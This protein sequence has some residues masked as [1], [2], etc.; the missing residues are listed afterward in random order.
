M[1]STR[2]ARKEARRATARTSATV[3]TR[4]TVRTRATV[5]TWLIGDR[6]IVWLGPL[7][8]LMAGTAGCTLAVDLD[9]LSQSDGSRDSRAPS[10]GVIAEASADAGADRAVEQ[11]GNF[12]A[13]A[14]G[15]HETDGAVLA[16]DADAGADGPL[17]P[18]GSSDAG[19][20]VQGS[21]EDS[22]AVVD[23]APYDAYPASDR[24]PPSERLDAGVDPGTDAFDADAGPE[25][26]TDQ[27]AASDGKDGPANDAETDV[28][29]DAMS[30][31]GAPSGPVTCDSA[32][33]VSATLHLLGS[34]PQVTSCGYSAADAPAFYAAVD[35]ETF[36]ASAACGVCLRIQTPAGMVAAMMVDLGPNRTA[37]NLTAIALNRD[38]LQ[39]LAPDGAT[40]V[41]QGVEWRRIPCEVATR[42]MTFTF[43]VGSNPSYAAVLIRNH[44]HGLAKVEYK[45]GGG[46]KELE[47]TSYNYWLAPTGMGA[48]PFTFRV[49]DVLGQSVE[50]TG[51]PLIPGQIFQGVTQFAP[52]VVN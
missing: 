34:L 19:A 44:R 27:A 8:V 42:G 47:R 28:A 20:D 40:L 35:P 1:S 33:A 4:V 37:A 15:I 31:D 25:S 11:N 48:G 22:A 13:G 24:P 49:T 36:A 14:V 50:E 5:R 45:S 23:A 30:V 6:T 46:Y 43:Q 29:I 10:D 32:P 39:I 3:H 9:G 51:I 12:D 17:E 16:G 7:V 26:P 38:A 52:C 21:G 18:A 2:L 41:E